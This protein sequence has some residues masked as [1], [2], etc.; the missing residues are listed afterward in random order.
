MSLLDDRVVLVTGGGSG[1]GREIAMLF[2]QNG[3]SVV[4]V[5]IDEETSGNVEAEINEA[6]GQ[7]L[8]V[9][10]DVTQPDQVRQ[11]VNQAVEK[12]NKLHILVNNAGICPLRS[13]EEI[14]LEEWNK[15]LAINLTGA[16]LLSQAALPY[17]RKAGGN[18]RI[19]NMGSLAG[20]IG[21]ISVGAHYSVS[22]GG[23]MILTKQL[24]KLLAPERVTVNNIAPGTTDT[25]LT[26][27]WP[28]E[29][30]ASLVHQI[31]LGR[32]GR[33][34]D[35]ANLAL[36]LASDAAEYITG[37]TININGGLFIG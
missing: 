5:D 27:A 4:I 35:V 9:K 1:I 11:A 30:R 24:A 34:E 32:L 15:V 13:F 7:A 26:Q 22:K 14:S 20:Q 21:G 36:F 17:L 25:A 29:I 31:P 8:A 12:F 33:P 2:S 10:C 23:L 3:A 16:F 37:A 19:I 6:G 18:G 28:E